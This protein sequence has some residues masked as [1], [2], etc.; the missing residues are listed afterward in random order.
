MTRVAQ[1]GPCRPLRRSHGLPASM[2]RHQ[3]GPYGVVLAVPRG[4]NH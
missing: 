2:A 3:P 4:P 1:F